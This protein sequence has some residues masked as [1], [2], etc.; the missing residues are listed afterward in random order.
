MHIHAYDSYTSAGVRT[1]ENLNLG[2]PNTYTIL[3]LNDQVECLKSQTQG[4][5]FEL[6]SGTILDL[7]PRLVPLY[8]HYIL[9]AFST[10]ILP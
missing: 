3:I 9:S 1:A 6:S 7:N 2:T 4:R 10:K 5:S 8:L